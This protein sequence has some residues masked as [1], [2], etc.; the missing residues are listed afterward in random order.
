M[1]SVRAVGRQ[2]AGRAPVKSEGADGAD[3]RLRIARL[4]GKRQRTEQHGGASGF[5]SSHASGWFHASLLYAFVSR[6]ERRD[7]A[8]R[9]SIGFSYAS[10]IYCYWLSKPCQILAHRYRAKSLRLSLNA[11]LGAV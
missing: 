1:F 2:I 7:K 3:I 4:R 10:N 8:G 11:W 5:E 9:R 6:P